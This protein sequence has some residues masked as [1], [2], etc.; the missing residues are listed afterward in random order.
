MDNKIHNAQDSVFDNKM[1]LSGKKKLEQLKEIGDKLKKG[2][3]EVFDSKRYK[4]YL[5][6]MSKFHNYSFRN[7]MLIMMQKPDASLVAGFQKWKKEFN[8]RVKAGE[9]AIKIIAPTPFTL[10][11]EVNVIDPKT[12]NPVLN[13]RGEPVTKEEDILIKAFK[14]VSVF[15]ISQTVGEPIEGLD[16]EELKGDVSSYAV[17]ME[18]IKRISPYPIYFEA[19]DDEATKGYCSFSS[20]KIVVKNNMSE[21]QKLETAIHETAHAVLHSPDNFK[22]KDATEKKDKNTMEVEAESVAYTVCQKYGVDTSEYSFGYIAAWSKSKELNELENSLQT[23]CVTAND[24]IEKIDENLKEL[25]KQENRSFAEEQ[26]DTEWE[27][28]M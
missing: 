1:E 11:R 25:M 28:E 16:L 21:A 8:R 24:L 4:K 14:T 26:E 22:D 6:T 10:T 18:A 2:V 12:N 27:I 5:D 19:I 17:L 9:K 20:K 13:E 23:I 3:K 15:D 7:I